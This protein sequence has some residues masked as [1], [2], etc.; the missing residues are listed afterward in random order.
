MI[1]TLVIG[2]A[3]AFTLPAFAAQ[4]ITG[5]WLT[6]DGDAVVA[7]APCGAALCGKIVKV[8]KPSPTNPDGARRAIGTAVLTALTPDGDGWKGRL[9]DPR[10]GKTYNARVTRD[11]GKL[12]VQGCV[13]VFCRTIVWTALR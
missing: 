6:A 5:Q 13:S 9:Y 4:P 1:R 8:T 11:G 10:N 7:I 3:L 12:N 2:L